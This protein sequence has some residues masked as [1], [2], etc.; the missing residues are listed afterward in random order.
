MIKVQ[1]MKTDFHAG[2]TI[3][4]KGEYFLVGNGIKDVMPR[5][6]SEKLI[7]PLLE[8]HGIE[9][10]EIEEWSIHQGGIPILEAFKSP[11]VLGLSDEQI[12]RSRKLF[13]RYGNFSTPSS[14]MVLE[15]FFNDTE[16]EK[17]TKGMVVAYG[18]GYY[19]GALLYEWE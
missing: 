4:M 13:E 6:A 18:A 15:S 1:D 12:A 8:S 14:L 10:E 11:D 2:N 17:G 7:K 5:L 9:K 19:I 3:K 16:R